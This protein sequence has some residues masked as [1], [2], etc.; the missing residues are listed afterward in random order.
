MSSAT[1]DD[2]F[3]GYRIPAGATIL[4]NHWGICFRFLI[5]IRLCSTFANVFIRSQGKN[6]RTEVRYTTVRA[7]SM[8]RATG[9]SW[10]Y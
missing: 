8:D 4:A 6:V 1:E 10:Q 7:T 9:R 2:L 5:L 3:N